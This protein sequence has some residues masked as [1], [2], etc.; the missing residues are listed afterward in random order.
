[1]RTST[2]LRSLQLVAVENLAYEWPAGV[3][4]VGHVALPFPVDDPVYGLLPAP[5]A[6]TQ[7]NLGA[8]APKGEA[9]ALVV[10][11]GTFERVRSNPFWGVIQAK[12][13]EAEKAAAAAH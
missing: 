13:V 8:L 1:M 6:Q 5:G 2:G 7:F 4:S 11:P 3:F 10:S 12:V 9:G